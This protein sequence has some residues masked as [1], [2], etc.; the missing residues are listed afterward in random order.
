M[1]DPGT[2]LVRA[3]VAKNVPVI[4][5][6]GPSA[7]TAA[8]AVSGLV[9]GPFLFLGFLPRRG[10][11]RQRVVRRMRTSPEPVVFFEAPGRIRETLTDLAAAMPERA[12]CVMR[13]LTKIHEETRRG[14]L[15]ELAAREITERGE[16]TVVVAC[17]KE[18]AGDDTLDVDAVIAERLGAGDSPR[19]VADDVASLS[20]KPRREIY[21]RVLE[22]VRLAQQGIWPA[23]RSSTGSAGTRENITLDVTRVAPDSS[24]DA[25]RSLDRKSSSRRAHAKLRS[26]QGSRTCG[27]RRGGSPG[28]QLGRGGVPV[29]R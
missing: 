11:K 27:S 18:E 1:S 21:G 8:V 22:A 26:A 17:T 7:V 9:D 25:L 10:E 14:T 20:G 28:A 12:A 16:F 29:R 6:P 19:T 4:T 24:A 3:A 15:A 13:E 23:P 2:K 5:I